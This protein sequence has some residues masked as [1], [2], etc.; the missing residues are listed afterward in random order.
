MT[1]LEDIL[2]EQDQRDL[3]GAPTPAGRVNHLGT[4]SRT[5]EEVLTAVGQL[6]PPAVRSG[7]LG[8]WQEIW[9]GRV[10]L[11]DYNRYICRD[12]QLG[13]PLLHAHTFTE[14]ADLVEGDT[15]YLPAGKVEGGRYRRSPIL[16][17]V[18]TAFREVAPDE[19]VCCAFA[20]VKTDDGVRPLL[21][22]RS[23]EFAGI[24]GATTI[25][26]LL[27]AHPDLLERALLALVN[28]ALAD[29]SA[30]ALDHV[31]GSS[32]DL[33][34][35]RGGAPRRVGNEFVVE[36]TTYRTAGHLVA[37]AIEG[38]RCGS[39]DHLDMHAQSRPAGHHLPLLG[40]TAILGLVAHWDR[41]AMGGGTHAHW[42]AI[43]MSG[44]P[45]M[46]GGYFG[47][48]ANR[49]TLRA[50]AEVLEQLPEFTS[51]VRF[52]LLPAP[53]LS[54]LAPVDFDNDVA[55]VEELAHTVRATTN[56]PTAD[57]TDALAAI[58]GVVRSWV[59][60]HEPLLSDY[61][62]NRFGRKRSVY[63]GSDMLPVDGRPAALG[64][65]GE[66]TMQQASMVVGALVEALAAGPN[67]QN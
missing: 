63:N 34:G 56:P 41:L 38:L 4:S 9:A 50:I 48:R 3:H 61:Y 15:I 51:A 65:I 67:A 14:T 66:L 47:R 18:G 1:S 28:E 62:R 52:A 35:R 33:Q 31:L 22:A 54:L 25:P 19:S 55:A 2:N 60:T 5:V 40:A 20:Y 36:E 58:T 30:L 59:G 23:H 26:T 8:N 29:G 24:A 44:Y 32:V 49:R 43:S 27:T 12:L 16:V 46:A 7:H 11:V 13:V 42:G 21:A 53:L 17:K 6:A 10:G 37:A 64:S 57:P 39:L 45:P